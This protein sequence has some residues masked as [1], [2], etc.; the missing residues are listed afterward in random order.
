MLKTMGHNSCFQ[1]SHLSIKSIKRL[2]CTQEDH[3]MSPYDRLSTSSVAVREV[4]LNARMIGDTALEFDLMTPRSLVWEALA[5][6]CRQ[7]G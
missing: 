2:P 7:R 6:N 1:T 4:A 3:A 5:A